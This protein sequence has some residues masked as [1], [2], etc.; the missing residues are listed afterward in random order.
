MSG[1]SILYILPRNLL[2]YWVGRLVLVKRPRVL[3]E[4]SVRLFIRFAKIRLDEAEYPLEH[5]HCIG[6]LFTRTLR[7]G[8]RPIQSPPVSPVDGIY[9]DSGRIINARLP[10]IKN[11]TYTTASLLAQNDLTPRFESG[12]YINLYLSPRHYHRVH[13]PISGSIIGYSHIPGTLWPV[14][15]WSLATIDQLFCINERVVVYIRTEQGLVAV[16]MVGATNVGKISLS[17]TSLLTNQSPLKKTQPVHTFM[18]APV[19][20]AIGD[21]L[22]VFHMGSTVVLLC[23]HPYSYNL[24]PGQEI[25]Y[26]EALTKHS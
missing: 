2:S 25:R 16:V 6:E 5:Y 9:R 14:N 26:G 15:D 18:E 4:L 10:Q 12:S 3:A 24:N 13:A 7:P 21:E 20:I 8:I 22:G 11:K 23:E 19:S 17:F 1:Y